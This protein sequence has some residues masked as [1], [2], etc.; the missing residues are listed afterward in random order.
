MQ[1]HKIFFTIMML[2]SFSISANGFVLPFYNFNRAPSIKYPFQTIKEKNTLYKIKLSELE[3]GNIQVGVEYLAHPDYFYK[4]HPFSDLDLYGIKNIKDHVVMV[5]KL[6]F[7]VN[8]PIDTFNEALTINEKYIRHTIS[9]VVKVAKDKN[10]KNKIKI[11]KSGK[12]FIFKYNI[13]FDLQS[14]FQD[15]IQFLKNAAA[16]QII[17]NLDFDLGDPDKIE[18]QE[19]SE[20]SGSFQ[21]TS[22][23]NRFHEFEKNK[24]LIVSYQLIAIKKSFAHRID[25]IP[26]KK[27]RKVFP[28]EYISGA[29]FLAQQMKTYQ[30]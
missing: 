8:Q 17:S 3:K 26:F 7:I 6:A 13:N 20:F 25:S 11:F 10:F 29:E 2:V 1:K 9:G 16:L 27:A 30:Y 23:F 19:I 22:N 5:G 24:T 4:N 14:E 18:F 15:K 28:S 12:K 21:Y